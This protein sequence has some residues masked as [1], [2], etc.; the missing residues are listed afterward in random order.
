MTFVYN[1]REQCQIVEFLSCGSVTNLSVSFTVRE[2]CVSTEA[3]WISDEPSTAHSAGVP[4]PRRRIRWIG[5]T[6]YHQTKQTEGLVQCTLW[7]RK[8]CKLDHSTASI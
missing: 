1:E 6:F 3:E 2:Q 8:N 5:P 4:R 7:G